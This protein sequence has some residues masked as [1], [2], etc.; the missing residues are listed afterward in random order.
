MIFVRRPPWTLSPCQQGDVR[1]QQVAP[2]YC[3][4][5]EHL[6]SAPKDASRVKTR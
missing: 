6:V 4:A 3:G 5:D 1:L 2:A